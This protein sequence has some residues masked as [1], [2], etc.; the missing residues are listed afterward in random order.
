MCRGAQNASF[1][2]AARTS[3]WTRRFI[4]ERLA[5]TPRLNRLSAIA[6]G[7]VVG[8]A[9]WVS[10]GAL[11]F[12]DATGSRRIGLVPSGWTLALAIAAAS[13]AF[14]TTATRT[15]PTRALLLSLVLLLPW[16]PFP[17]PDAFLAWT[18]PITALVWIGVLLCALPSLVH[19]RAMPRLGIVSDARIAPRIAFLLAFVILLAVRSRQEL[20]PTGDEPH[21]LLIAQSVV[22]DHDFKVANNYET[23]SY[24]S[25]YNGALRPHYSRRSVD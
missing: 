3:R 25:F 2:P 13:V 11:A 19:D 4:I 8:A 7:V 22:T 15:Q 17:V 12:T 21:Y 14:L 24:S 6:A 20:P 5:H 18:G 1:D 9:I 16:L 10:F 23:Q